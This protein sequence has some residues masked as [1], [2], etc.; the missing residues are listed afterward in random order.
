MRCAT[1]SIAR[2]SLTI[3]ILAAG[4]LVMNAD[5]PN[6]QQLPKSRIDKV[7]VMP[8]VIVLSKVGKQGTVTFNHKRH[9][10]GEYNAGGPILCTECHHTA[11]PASELVRVPPLKTA[12]PADRTTTLT[13]E[14]YAEDPKKA[15]VAACRDCHARAG[16]KPK[17]LSKIPI[18]DDGGS[19]TITKLTS[20][21]A[22][23]QACDVCHFQIGFRASDTKAPKATNCA[24][25][26]KTTAR[27]H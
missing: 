19:G 6:A 22:F 23:H 7:K 15:G 20:E 21:I 16:S 3:L 13:A 24:S 2:I 10:S 17:L 1:V 11:Q 25:C 27:K 4:F 26:H 14:L 9:N 5:R 18:F 12:W 8:E